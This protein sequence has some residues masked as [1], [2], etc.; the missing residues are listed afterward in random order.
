[1][2][3]RQ[4]TPAGTARLRS[5][6][7]LVELLVVIAIIGT[8]VAL[9]LPAV[10]SARE[11]ARGNTC[12]NNL[13]QLTLALINYDTTQRKLPGLV[14]EIAN[15]NS[16]RIPTSGDYQGE[17]SVGRRAS[18]MVVLFPYLEQG[19]LWDQWTQN[20]SSGG[21]IT[22]DLTP[23]LLDA[24]CPSDA[25]ESPGTPA[26]S[27]VANAGQAYFC[28]SRGTS[29]PAGVIAAGTEYASNG[30][31]FDLNRKH[32]GISSNG[33]PYNA[34]GREPG[35]GNFQPALQSSI[36]TISSN[37]GTSKTFMLSENI[38]AIWYT[39]PNQLIEP[40]GSSPNVQDMADAKHF[41]GFVWHNIPDS[42]DTVGVQR[43]NGGLSPEIVPPTSFAE[44]LN[45]EYLGYP[46]SN[47][48]SSVNFALCDGSVRSV[49]DRL[50]QEIYAQFMTTK[51]K[52]SKYYNRDTNVADR[53]LGQP[54]VAD[55]D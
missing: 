50:D 26:T 53:Q 23:E 39:Y 48:P 11:T 35:G 17:F 36:D 1:M 2:M 47:H 22:T 43:L 5:G 30:V 40:P 52:R 9:L 51:Y 24:Q 27:Y 31:F 42:N 45:Q 8:L 28:G 21:T 38:H 4:G 25:P 6:F 29:S 54:S 46:S 37:D 41:F 18:W 12:R 19:P 33:W 34:D 10:Q 16:A 32:R 13:K 55:L 14:N 3:R 20:F 15:P 7:T 44:L 49:T